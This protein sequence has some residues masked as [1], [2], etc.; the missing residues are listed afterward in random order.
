MSSFI[1]SFCLADLHRVGSSCRIQL[2]YPERPSLATLSK[3]AWP[4]QGTHY[5]ILVFMDFI[6][7]HKQNLPDL[8]S[9]VLVYCMSSPFKKAIS[10]TVAVLPGLFIAVSIP[11][12][13]ST[14]HT[15]G[16]Q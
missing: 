3:L 5:H 14:W 15:V 1:P 10:M 4:P 12:V 11:F 8:S 6:K 2:K 16:T 13:E 7:V 9:Y